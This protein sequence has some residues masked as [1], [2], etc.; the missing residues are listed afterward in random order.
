MLW[1]LEAQRCGGD[2]G[3]HSHYLPVTSRQMDTLYD[4]AAKITGFYWV[5]FKKAAFEEQSKILLDELIEVKACSAWSWNLMAIAYT[6]KVS[7]IFLNRKDIA[8]ISACIMR[9]LTLYL[10]VT[11]GA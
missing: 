4:V 2:R 10:Q 11:Y 9:I 7:S 1:I 8:S 6:S 5:K 3:I